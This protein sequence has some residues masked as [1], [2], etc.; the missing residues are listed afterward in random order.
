VPGNSVGVNRG[1]ETI[2]VERLDVGLV[3]GVRLPCVVRDARDHKEVVLALVDGLDL[4][5]NVPADT[6]LTRRHRV[7]TRV[8]CDRGGGPSDARD[9]QRRI[10][11]SIL[12]GVDVID[13]RKE[14][15][16][17]RVRN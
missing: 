13:P 11:V 5:E 7:G 3:C 4:V 15:I 6:I 9:E 2:V 14:R 17:R 10:N 16:V 1:K 8:T 12:G